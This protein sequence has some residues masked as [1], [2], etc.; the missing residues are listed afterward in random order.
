MAG[1]DRKGAAPVAILDY[2]VWR[3]RFGGDYA[4][5]GRSLSLNNVPVEVVGV[6]PEGFRFP[7]DDIEVWLPI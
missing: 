4:I 1:D 6:M 2:E 3:R 7:Y 5:V